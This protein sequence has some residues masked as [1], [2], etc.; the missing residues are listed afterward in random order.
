MAAVKLALLKYE[1]VHI[2]P[3]FL[4][5]GC[6]FESF[7]AWNRPPNFKIIYPTLSSSI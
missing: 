4:D 1:G 3:N 6:K 5:Q 7:S 2:L